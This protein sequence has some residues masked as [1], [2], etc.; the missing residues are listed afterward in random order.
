MTAAKATRQRFKTEQPQVSDATIARIR[1][2]AHRYVMAGGSIF[3][4]EDDTD[5]DQH[6]A[7][8]AVLMSNHESTT[9]FN[10][11]LKKAVPDRDTH[12]TIWSAAVEMASEDCCAAF[13][14]GA[15]VGI[16]L[17]NLV[18]AGKGGAR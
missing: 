11:C 18:P 6:V 14:F 9:A 1:A 5:K 4:K 13:L 7:N 12:E 16:E 2:M 15:F 17:A 8:V 10:A 3:P